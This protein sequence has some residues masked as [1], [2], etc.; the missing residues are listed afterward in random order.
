[1]NSRLR[2]NDVTLAEEER[3]IS[4]QFVRRRATARF[5]APLGMTRVCRI[6][7]GEYA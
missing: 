1:M 3:G 6:R 2:G 4:L 5:L 7:Y